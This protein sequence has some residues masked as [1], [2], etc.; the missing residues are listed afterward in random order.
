MAAKLAIAFDGFS[1]SLIGMA[2]THSRLD[3]GQL[4]SL[5][6][7]ALYVGA[8][9]GPSLLLLP[10]LAAELAGPASILAWTGL[11]GLSG[12]LAWVFT[13]L[14]TRFARGGV[15]GYTAAGFGERAGRMISWCFVCGVILGAPVVC[16]IGGNYVADLLGAGLGVSVLAAATLLGLIVA[17]TLGGARVTTGVQLGLVAVLI[18]LVVVAVVGSAPAAT[19]TSW[20]PFLPHG[21]TS[22]G[23]AAAVLMLSFVGW[24]AIAPLTGR[25][26]DRRRQ[27]PRVIGAAFA[28]TAVVYLGLATT[29]IGVL[30]ERAGSA[31]PLADLL[32]VAVGPVG[33]VAATLAAVALT[34]GAA[35]AYLSGAAALVADLRPAGS[36]TGMR[37]LQ[38]GIVGAGVVIIGGAASGLLSG[39]ELV[40][41]PTTLFLVVYVG[42]TAAAFRILRGAVRYAAGLACVI[43][44]GVLAFSGWPLVLTGVVLLVGWFASRGP[45]RAEPTPPAVAASSPGPPD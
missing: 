31:V 5:R 36:G 23:S 42:C 41:V 43:V 30:G 28:I 33:S 9:L 20:T 2:N 29:T 3:S 6:G 1:A 45:N 17:L 21:W 13:A 16:L 37:W 7:A 32:R 24:E 10:G 8:L 14:G 12:L 22:L 38:L 40:N 19:A 35:N 39:A 34:L 15:A 4:S 18:G 44:L 11:L 27:L 26:R 25:L